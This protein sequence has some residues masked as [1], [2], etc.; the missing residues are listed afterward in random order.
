MKRISTI[1]MIFIEPI[2]IDMIQEGSQFRG[3]HGLGGVD[4]IA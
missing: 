3:A 4:S 1:S 2:H